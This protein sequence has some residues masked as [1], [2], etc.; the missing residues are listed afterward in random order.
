MDSL[1]FF[2][3]FVYQH[4]LPPRPVPA[5]GAERRRLAG[6]TVAGHTVTEQLGGISPSIVSLKCLI[7]SYRHRLEIE[8]GEGSGEKLGGKE[9]K[10]I[11]LL[12]CRK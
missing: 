3:F 9:N 8:A 12:K 4:R 7:Y 10:W 6:A 2:F 1:F 11:S 5:A